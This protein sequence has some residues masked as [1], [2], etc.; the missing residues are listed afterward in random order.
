ME[1]LLEGFGIMQNKLAVFIG[2]RPRR[3][4]RSRRSRWN[5]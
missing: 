1:D 5:A 3:A 4:L 2:V